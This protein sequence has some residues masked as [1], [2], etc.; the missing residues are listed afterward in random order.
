[1]EEA[2]VKDSEIE[3]KQRRRGDAL[4][5]VERCTQITESGG[6]AALSAA[7]KARAES[8][9]CSYLLSGRSASQSLTA[10]D[11]YCRDDD[12]R[13]SMS[14]TRWCERRP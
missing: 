11:P 7:S 13:A 3:A 12:D 2:Q 1:M 8:L 5:P 10:R 14:G 9:P 4:K 6:S